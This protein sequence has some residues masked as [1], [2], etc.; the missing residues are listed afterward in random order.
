MTF[1]GLPDEVRPDTLLPDPLLEAW[2]GE[3]LPSARLRSED[4]APSE[5]LH[6]A[7]LHRDYGVALLDLAPEARPDAAERFRRLHQFLYPR[8]PLPPVVYCSLAPTDLWRL[9][10]ILDSAFALEPPLA[11]S[12]ADWMDRA[13]EILGGEPE[14]PPPAAPVPIEAAAPGPDAAVAPAE[15]PARPPAAPADPRRRL[16]PLLLLPV[17]AGIAIAVA[18][19]LLRP[20]QPGTGGGVPAMS[21]APTLGDPVQ[22]L[23]V[24]APLSVPQG[25]RGGG[26]EPKE[27]AAPA[28]GTTQL[29]GLVQ[30][31][32]QEAGPETGPDAIPQHLP[33]I[34]ALQAVAAPPSRLLPALEP[35]PRQ[36]AGPPAAL[37]TPAFE[38]AAAPMSS[39]ASGLALPP[40]PDLF[41]DGTAVGPSVLAALQPPGIPVLAPAPW[42]DTPPLPEALVPMPLPPL[43]G[44]AAPS[45]EIVVAALPPAPAPPLPPDEAVRAEAPE[46]E[47]ARPQEPPRPQA[48][49]AP[50]TA[51]PALLLLLLR[52]GDALLALGDVSAARLFYERAAAA[53]SAPA[54]IAMARTYDPAI[55][56]ELGVRG[57]RPERDAAIAWYRRAVAL[58]GAGAS[59]PLERLEA[60]GR[61]R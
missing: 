58:G 3:V 59:G 30:D 4:G 41:R 52:R 8:Q 19:P 25:M 49:P 38:V 43:P 9:T 15:A 46:E 12:G 32:A 39:G 1:H 60:G 22:Q 44:G 57:L 18:L 16:S 24:E 33:L 40:S 45:G 54:A 61:A 23:A 7:L 56:G 37:E 53:G 31:D 27:S 34:A 48:A 6:C 47:P 35:V 51:D 42:P 36:P 20:P 17:L 26:E 29:T 28:P 10:I 11:E 5:R 14:P 55:L 2:G 21:V 50:P 13:R